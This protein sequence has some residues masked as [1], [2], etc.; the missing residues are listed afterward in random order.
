MWLRNTLAGQIVLPPPLNGLGTCIENQQ[1]I[2]YIRIYLIYEGQPWTACPYTGT[3][4][5]WLLQ[6]YNMFGDWEVCILQLPPSF[7][8]LLQLFRVPLGLLFPQKKKKKCQRYYTESIHH[9]GY[10]VILI[11]SSYYWTYYVFE[12]LMFSL[13]SFNAVIFLCFYKYLFGIY[14]TPGTILKCLQV[15]SYLSPLHIPIKSNFNLILWIKKLKEK[16]V[17]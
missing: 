10:Y 6:L 7:L 8:R 9:F 16:E 15:L 11:L 12:L 2:T 17:K 3:T 13:I 5:F 1:L 4:L 14:S